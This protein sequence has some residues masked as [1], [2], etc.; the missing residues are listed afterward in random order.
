MN[1]R[2]RSFQQG[3]AYS[4]PAPK[5]Y[6]SENWNKLQR[7]VVSFVLFKSFRSNRWRALNSNDGNRR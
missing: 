5:T 1:D 2:G 7:A 3:R 4:L 6:P